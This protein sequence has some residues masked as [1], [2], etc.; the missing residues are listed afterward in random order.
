MHF[1]AL[2]FFCCNLTSDTGTDVILL[3]LERSNFKK[4]LYMDT[5]P[6]ASLAFHQDTFIYIKIT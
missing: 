4:I 5:I 6:V 1:E 2:G 3:N